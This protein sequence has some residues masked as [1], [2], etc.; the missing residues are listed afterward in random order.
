MALQRSHGR[1][2]LDD[3]VTPNVVGLGALVDLK[4][5]LLLVD[6]ESLVTR[7]MVVRPSAHPTE[8]GERASFLVLAEVPAWVDVPV[9]EGV[10]SDQMERFVREAAEQH[11]IDWTRPF[12]FVV[13]GAISSAEMHVINGRC[14]LAAGELAPEQ[15]P[16]RASFGPGDGLLVGFYGEGVEAVLTHHGSRMHMHGLLGGNGSVNRAIVG[17]LD[18]VGLDVGAILQLPAR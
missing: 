8:P 14:P 1:V 11:G 3:V 9:R 12:P 17:H 5:E 16:F 2:T 13:R 6:G 4:G 7:A 15:E 18:A 10:P